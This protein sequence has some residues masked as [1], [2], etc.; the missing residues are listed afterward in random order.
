MEAPPSGSREETVEDTVI[1]KDDDIEVEKIAYMNNQAWGEAY[2]RVDASRYISPEHAK[3]EL[4]R[5][6]PNVWQV[7]CREEE[8]AK[9]GDYFEYEIGD[10]S[11]IVLRTESGALKAYFN[12]CQHRGTQLLKGCGHAK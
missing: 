1:H 8:V 9:P 3:L 2:K 5:L 4:E 10:Q 11:I 12:A 7:A 6:W